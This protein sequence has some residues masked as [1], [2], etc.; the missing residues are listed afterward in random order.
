MLLKLSNHPVIS[1]CCTKNDANSQ[2]S[3]KQELRKNAKSDCASFCE[4][5]TQL[6]TKVVSCLTDNVLN[7]AITAVLGVLL[8]LFWLRMTQSM[9]S[10]SG[11]GLIHHNWKKL[12]VLSRYKVVEQQKTKSWR[13]RNCIME[14]RTDE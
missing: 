9:L 6:K 3:A 10:M 5:G 11:C 4:P 2:L 1:E 13:Q 7:N 14:Q 12:S 8:P